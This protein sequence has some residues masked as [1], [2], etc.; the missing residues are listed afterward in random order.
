MT[1]RSQSEET[2]AGIK[3]VTLSVPADLDGSTSALRTW[4]T[5]AGADGWRVLPPGSSDGQGIAEQVEL[6]LDSSVAALALYD[7]VRL[8]IRRRGNRARPVT[9]V[10]VVEIDGTKYKLVV[11]LSP[12][13]NDNDRA[14]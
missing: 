12:L 1:K 9:A 4:L 8:W 13:E 7:R 3:A 14:A 11:T 10:L 5:S 6:A 2:A